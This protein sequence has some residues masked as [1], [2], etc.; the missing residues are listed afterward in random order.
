MVNYLA[1]GGG[2]LKVALLQSSGAQVK[3]YSFSDAVPMRGDDTA[4]R[5]SWSTHKSLP[6]VLE[7]MALGFRFEGDAQL[8]SFVIV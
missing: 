7:G 4:E 2:T 3:G 6:A 5:A 1:S 8:Y